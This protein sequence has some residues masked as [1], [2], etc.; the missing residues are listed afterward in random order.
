MTVHLWYADHH[1]VEL[2]PGHRFPM[3]KYATV[4]HHLQRSALDA[5]FVAAAPASVDLVAGAH[6][7]GYVERFASG[8]LTPKEMRRV[9]FPWSPQ[10]VA[11]TLASVAGTVMAT[12]HALGPA[13]AAGN[14]AGGTHHA[15]RD[16]GE[17]FCVFNDNAVAVI[18]ARREFGVERVLV[19]DLDVHQGNGTA[20]MFADDPDVLTLSVHGARNYP[21]RKERGDIDVEL[22][23]GTGDDAYLAVLAEHL[24]RA[25]RAHHP[26]LVMYQAGV[27]ALAEDSLGRLALTLDGLARRDALVFEHVAW[28][29]AR[30]VVTMGGG[31]ARPIAA[32]VAAHAQVYAG[33]AAAFNR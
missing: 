3:A 32:S 2:P 20:A 13:R 33:F 31:Y 28:N 22:P 25:C 15:Y 18:A 21:F 29:D 16:R 11:R 9:G 10:L 14:L 17:G 7:E 24:G 23:D 26:D 6:D 1:E 12:R 5:T 19:V 4:R 27:D 8:A 30:L